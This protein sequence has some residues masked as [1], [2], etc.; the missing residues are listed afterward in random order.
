MMYGG[1][2]EI[3]HK[4]LYGPRGPTA[5]N[6]RPDFA[7]E[8]QVNNTRSALGFEWRAGVRSTDSSTSRTSGCP[9]RYLPETL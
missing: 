4:S 3:D 8:S 5:R 2:S 9:V 1:R 6:Y 7:R